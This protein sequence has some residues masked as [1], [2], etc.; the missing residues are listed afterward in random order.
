MRS[1][2]AED[3]LGKNTPPALLSSGG[4]HRP[5]ISPNRFPQ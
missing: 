2:Q 3:R 5:A 4:L 1:A